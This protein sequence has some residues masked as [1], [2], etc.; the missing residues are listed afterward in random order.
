MNNILSRFVRYMMNNLSQFVRYMTAR[1]RGGIPVWVG[2]LFLVVIG[3]SFLIS[4]E[5]AN[6]MNSFGKINGFDAQKSPLASLFSA[7]GFIGGPVIGLILL[8]K[9]RELL[10]WN[11]ILYLAIGV[12]VICGVV[13][14][15]TQDFAIIC[16]VRTLQG[17]V[18][19]T[20]AGLGVAA[21]GALFDSDVARKL[22]AW[23]QPSIALGVAIGLNVPGIAGSIRGDWPIV[24]MVITIFIGLAEA[25]TMRV[26]PDIRP[27][28]EAAQRAEEEVAAQ[29]QGAR[30]AFRK[31]FIVFA[32]LG[33]SIQQ[34]LVNGLFSHPEAAL[35]ALGHLHAQAVAGVGGNMAFAGAV[36]AAVIA[37]FVAP[38][39]HFPISV[40]LL[41]F[42]TI[43]LG[44]GFLVNSAVLE[45]SY[46]AF[47]FCYNLGVGTL[48]APLTQ[49][50]QN[51]ATR[52]MAS[53][54]FIVSQGFISAGFAYVFLPLL[55]GAPAVL[56]FGSAIAITTV[57]AVITVMYQKLTKPRK[58]AA[59][60][61]ITTPLDQLERLAQEIEK[62]RE[63]LE[64]AKEELALAREQ[65]VQLG[66]LKTQLEE[67]KRDSR[68]TVEQLRAAQL[69][70][71][72]QEIQR[73]REHLASA[74]EELELAREYELRLSNLKAQLEEAR[75]DRS[76]TLNKLNDTQKRID[77]LQTFLIEDSK[78]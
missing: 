9:G 60:A 12:E 2:Y 74:K 69:A 55:N 57:G 54:V 42:A 67:A 76:R 5:F 64:Q 30:A 32:A 68:T 58:Q 22:N 63:L 50:V 62:E 21:I 73:E 46:Y 43:A 40:A 35:N 28:M 20:L 15:I 56:F 38:K 6:E 61:T 10:P 75:S 36:V 19:A 8:A 11:R 18:Q 34:I 47:A 37:S 16:I 52:Q 26:I 13:I 14:G 31:S 66:N 39:W 77:D 17:A 71:F 4:S 72:T 59:P 48:A 65:E 70:L 3:L 24:I 25:A 1:G 29:I 51:D 41:A 53:G 33:G 78:R 49:E 7:L 44:Y 27:L 23:L 45:P